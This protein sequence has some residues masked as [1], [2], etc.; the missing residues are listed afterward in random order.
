MHLRGGLSLIHGTEGQAWC[1]VNG[2]RGLM[3]N[4]GGMGVMGDLGGYGNYGGHGYGDYGD[5]RGVT[6]LT[7]GGFLH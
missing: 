2:S 7:L 1:P 3:G 4:D 6:L 5:F